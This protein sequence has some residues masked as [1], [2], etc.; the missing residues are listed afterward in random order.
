MK[1]YFSTVTKAILV[2]TNTN[3]TSTSGVTA[4]CDLQWVPSLM[5]LCVYRHYKKVLM[6]LLIYHPWQ[7]VS[8]IPCRNDDLLATIHIEPYFRM[9]SLACL[10]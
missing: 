2:I 3:I 7:L 10:T 4:L 8:W 9:N 6:V 1:G 5:S